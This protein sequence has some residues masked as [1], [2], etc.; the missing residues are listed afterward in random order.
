MEIIKLENQKVS[1]QL[2]DYEYEAISRF[3]I[4]LNVSFEDI[5][6]IYL[7][8]MYNFVIQYQST[9]VKYGT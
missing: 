3:S 1:I 4:S 5:F 6:Q 8:S 9:A 7:R 2:T